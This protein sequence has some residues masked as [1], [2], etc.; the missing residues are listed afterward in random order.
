[1]R[2]VRQAETAWIPREFPIV[3]VNKVCDGPDQRLFPQ[4]AGEIRGVAPDRDFVCQPV[5][6]QLA[7]VLNTGVH[8]QHHGRE[9]QISYV[10][11]S[12]SNATYR[13]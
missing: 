7:E 9:I 11:G 3:A 12:G 10:V 6:I 8:C 2:I 1:M 4:D 5:S 13:K